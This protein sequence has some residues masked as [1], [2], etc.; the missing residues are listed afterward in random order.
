VWEK[1]IQAAE[2]CN[3]PGRF[4]AFVGFEWTSVPKGNDLHR[5]VIFRDGGDRARQV[6]PLTT[7]E[8]IGTTYPLD[9]YDYLADY[10]SKTGGKVFALAHNGNLSNGWMFPTEQTYAG[11]VVDENYVKLRARWEPLYKITQVKGD[12]GPH[13]ALSPDDEFADY[14]TWDAGHLDLSVAKTE[15][16]LQREYAREALKQGFVLQKKLGVNPHKFGFSGATDSHTSLATAEEDS[17][18]G[19]AADA[20]PSTTRV[21]HPFTKTDKGA[22]EGYERV[23]SGYT[24]VWATENTC[25]ALWDAM[26]RREVYA[27]T[28]RRMRVRF[29]GGWDFTDDDLRSR[30]PAFRVYEKG[31][32]MGADLPEK[33]GDAPTFMVYALHDPIGA[34]LDCIQIVPQANAFCYARVLFAPGDQQQARFRCQLHRHL[35]T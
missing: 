29:F 8:P 4:T 34:N 13:P 31:V 19:K 26:V 21:E 23:A 11:G 35:C 6:V 32:P 33:S 25:E 30:A 16:M 15:D 12:G 28:G 1:T 27:T 20:E 18:W 17:F 3:E 22:F 5:N 14:E 10:E 9:L 7:L 24:G 2:K